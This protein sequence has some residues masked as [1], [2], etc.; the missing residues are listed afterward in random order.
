LYL[1]LP[2]VNWQPHIIGVDQS[3]AEYR[4][5][6]D[7]GH[8]WKSAP[9]QGLPNNAKPVL[10]PLI[11][12][13][14]GSLV[15]A[16]SGDAPGSTK[17][18]TWK[19]GEASWKVFAPAPDGLLSTVLRTVSATGDETYWAVLESPNALTTFAVLSYQP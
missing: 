5:S 19:P 1:N 18:Y 10:A 8:T 7:G 6:A 4:V 17:L 14:D 2:A 12:R 16:F 15:V 3:P 11:V 13:A 9:S